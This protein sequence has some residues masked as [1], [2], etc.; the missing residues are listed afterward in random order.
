M[1]RRGLDRGVEFRGRRT[2]SFDCP[3]KGYRVLVVVLL[4]LGYHGGLLLVFV[5]LLKLQ[6]RLLLLFVEL[7]V[8]ATVHAVQ[9]V[10]KHLTRHT[11][12]DHDKMAFVFLNVCRRDRRRGD[13]VRKGLRVVRDVPD[14]HVVLVCLRERRVRDRRQNECKLQILN[15]AHRRNCLVLRVVLALQV[16]NF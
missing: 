14:Q 15:R 6:L 7:F 11:A 5:V 2:N 4:L 13:Q 16:L 12:A 3:R 8:Y 1:L 9:V 10:H